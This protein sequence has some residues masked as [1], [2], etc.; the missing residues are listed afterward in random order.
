M[1]VNVGLSDLHSAVIAAGIP[2]DGVADLGGGQYRI[3][4][5][6]EA[7][8]NQRTQAAAIAS[9]FDMSP[10]AHG[11]RR[12]A[13]AK[14]AAKDCVSSSAAEMRLLRA[15]AKTE[16]QYIMENRSKL[17]Q[18]LTAAG[19]ATLPLKTFNQFANDVKDVIDAE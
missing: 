8:N 9:S 5:K 2:I 1:E 14:A 16:L 18:L 7:T 17:N 19:I 6:P 10:E 4:F 12:T 3:D 15:A 13:A 11:S